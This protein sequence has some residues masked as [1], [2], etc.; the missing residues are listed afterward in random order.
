[1]ISLYFGIKKQNK[2]QT[3][4]PEIGSQTQTTDWW[5][6]WR[7]GVGRRMKQVKGKKKISE[8]VRYPDLDDG[9]I[10][11]DTCQNSLS[12][13]VKFVHFILSTLTCNKKI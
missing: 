1:M 11:V 4:N 8:H 9:F 13:P 2:Q 7:M 10:S 6:P 12:C 5:L 3:K